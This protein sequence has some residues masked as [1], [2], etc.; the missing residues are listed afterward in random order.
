MLDGRMD[1]EHV[2]SGGIAINK[3]STKQV[4]MKENKTES[5]LKG[6]PEAGAVDHNHQGGVVT[7]L[8]EFVPF[9]PLVNR[10]KQSPS[11]SEV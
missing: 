6:Q 7:A 3:Q 4:A 9:K 5:E 1:V 10:Y 8:G 2:S 11:A